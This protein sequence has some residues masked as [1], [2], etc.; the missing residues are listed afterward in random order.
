[1]KTEALTLALEA[2]TIADNIALVGA[3]YTPRS[4]D[5]G[6]QN[7][8]RAITAIKEALAQPEQE[9]M[10]WIHNFIEGGISIGKRP[11]DLDRHPD[12]WTALYPEPKPCPTCE[13]LARTV[14]FDQTS[15]DT[16]PPQRTWVGLTI[17]EANELWESTDSDWELMKR[18]EAKL[19]EKNT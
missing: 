18:T 4:I 16:T 3:A 15:N 7:I 19:K 12:R 2:L 5:L 8:S 6:L 11:I 14:M 9:P 17:Q 1:M 10:A 13:A